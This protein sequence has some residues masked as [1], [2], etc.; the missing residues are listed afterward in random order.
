MQTLGRNLVNFASQEKAVLPVLLLTLAVKASLAN[1][2]LNPQQRT[3]TKL[4]EL[5]SSVDA[6]ADLCKENPVMSTECDACDGLGLYARDKCCADMMEF[7]SC[8]AQLVPIVQE[9]EAQGSDAETVEKRYLARW[10]LTKGESPVQWGKQI[11]RY[12]MASGRRFNMNKFKE[13]SYSKQGK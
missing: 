9:W 2:V 5:Y 3:I 6:S 4:K 8:H 7:S 1:D 12:G 11:K 13:G 10:G